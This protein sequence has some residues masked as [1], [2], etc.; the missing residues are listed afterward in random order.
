MLI[1]PFAM[2]GRFWRGN[3]HA[4]SSASDGALAPAAIRD[5]Y[6]SVGYDFLAITDHFLDVFGF[7]LTDVSADDGPD[8]VTVRSAELHA[9]RIEAGERWHMLG[10]GLPADFLPTSDTET[11][12][13]LA[14]RALATGAFVAAA[15]PAW[16]GATPAEIGSLGPIHAVEVWNATVADFER[17]ARQLVRRRPT[18]EPRA[19]LLRDSS[20]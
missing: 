17:S 14:A 4:H 8:F 9:G 19:A 16:Y 7:P 15:H 1:H 2:P 13:G 5:L 12:P 3:L 6:R 20:R 18:A 11:G 10:I